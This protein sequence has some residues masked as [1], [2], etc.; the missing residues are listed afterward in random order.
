M[1]QPDLADP[2]FADIVRELRETAPV[3]PDA[4][5]RRVD[6]AARSQQPSRQLPVIG[7]R[8]ALVIAAA[9]AVALSL[10]VAGINSLRNVGDSRNSAVSEKALSVRAPST[11]GRT[12]QPARGER[13][14]K[15]YD[16]LEGA[17]AA[18]LPPGRRL[19]DYH[20]EMRLRV[21]NAEALDLATKR[22]MRET[23]RLGGFVSSINFG[24]RPADEG[25]ARLV[26]RVPIRKIQ[27]A[28]AT[29]SDLGTIVSQ[30][31]V[32]S[33]LQPQADRLSREIERLVRRVAELRAKGSLTFEE[34]R[35]LA[36]AEHRL[37][38]LKRQRAGLVRQASYATVSL[39]LTTAKPAEKREEPSAF[40]TFLDDAGSILATQLLW[41]LYAL[42]VA[43]PFLLLAS[44]VLMAER[45]RRRRANDALLAHH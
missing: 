36:K 10:A 43:G 1:S 15:A 19:Q 4:L 3:A 20:A 34:Q 35:E 26:L 23:R 9:A 18:T 21:K 41:L 8:R 2:R 22:A 40:R 28:V 37:D 14:F 38:T 5:R 30:R 44:L 6:E 13:V 42:V 17:R 45:T 33:D 7:L 29:F 24:T 39:D 16:T 32:I 25:D 31:V 27:Q 11:V 12:R